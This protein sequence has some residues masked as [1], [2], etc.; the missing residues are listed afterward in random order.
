MKNEIYCTLILYCQIRIRDHADT[1]HLQITVWTT[2][3][4]DWTT[5]CD[6][7]DDHADQVAS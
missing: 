2:L 6:T 7:S 5:Y 1:L 3:L 4:Q